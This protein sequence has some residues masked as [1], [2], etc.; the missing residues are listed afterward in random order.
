M[1]T[2]YSKENLE[3]IVKESYSLSDVIRALGLVP[4]GSNFSNIK[5]Y[6]EKYKINTDHFIGSA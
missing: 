2:N 3:K 4:K 1:K 6:I 5:K